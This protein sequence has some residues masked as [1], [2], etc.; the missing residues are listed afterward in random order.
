METEMSR[1]VLG[2]L[3]RFVQNPTVDKA[4]QINGALFMNHKVI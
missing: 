2:L 3:N 1:E 4:I